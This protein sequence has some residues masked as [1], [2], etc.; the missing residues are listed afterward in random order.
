MLPF[1]CTTLPFHLTNRP[2]QNFIFAKIKLYHCFYTQSQDRIDFYFYLPL[3][4][5][6]C[7]LTPQSEPP[8]QFRMTKYH[9]CFWASVSGPA[10]QLLWVYF[11]QFSYTWEKSFLWLKLSL[12]S[13]YCGFCCCIGLQTHVIHL[14]S[15]LHPMGL[16]FK[17]NCKSVVLCLLPQCIPRLYWTCFELSGWVALSWS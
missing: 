13:S 12:T 14:H 4:S 2:V 8:G 6:V 3:L 15:V 7:I 11:A 16:L 9:H 10:D 1:L 17:F 5:S